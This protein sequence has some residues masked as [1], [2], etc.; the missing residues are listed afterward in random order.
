MAAKFRIFT[1]FAIEDAALRTLLVGQAKNAR[2][3]FEFVDMS[4]QS[5]SIPFS[6]TEALRNF[7]SSD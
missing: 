1:S 6:S 5:P 4:V 3:P 2:T 7:F